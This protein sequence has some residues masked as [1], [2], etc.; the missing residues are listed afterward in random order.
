MKAT[1][2]PDL[3]IGCGVCEGICSKVFSMLDSDKAEVIH[4]PSSPDEEACT[5]E[6]VEACP[7][8]AISIAE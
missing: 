1:I 4:Q 2:D 5:K 6:A 8:A 3:C 7:V